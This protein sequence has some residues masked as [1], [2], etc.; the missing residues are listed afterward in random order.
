[1]AYAVRRAL[2]RTALYRMTL[3]G[4]VAPLPGFVPVD[5]WPGNVDRGS[6]IVKGD[7]EFAGNSVREAEAP[8]LAD[9]ISV[10][11][12]AAISEFDW[13]RDLRTV[14]SDAARTRARALILRWI[15][16]FGEWHPVTWRPD[17]LGARVAN[18]IGQCEF[19]CAGSDADFRDAFFQNLRRQ[20]RHLQRAARFAPAGIGR[21]IVLKGLIYA[22]LS[23]GN[24][25]ALAR[26]IRGLEEEIDR[27]V[28]VDGGYITRNPSQQLDVMRHL[29][30][31]R[32]ALRAAQEDVPHGLQTAIDRMAPMLRFFRHGDGG[33]ALFN[34]SR[35]EEGWFID[36]VLTR[37]EARG[38][39]L[40]SAPHVGFER[41]SANR[42]LVL[43]DVGSPPPP[44][45]D[46]D[47]HAGRST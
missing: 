19:L 37:S 23:L 22:A 42:T 25:K 11:W 36:V 21:I 6:I 3:P 5:M 17:V 14:S 26:W 47:A 20:M 40:D 46:D 38:K 39:P 16:S 32:A 35:E 41:L 18:W 28:L 44:G 4:S 7:F 45:V 33:L 27:Q 15:D 13:L 2:Y 10:T 12:L 29:V 43:M 34:G 1:M 31:V 24:G 30:D 8:W 9:S